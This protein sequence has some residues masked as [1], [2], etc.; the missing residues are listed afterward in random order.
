[1]D[2]VF[3]FSAGPAALPLEVLQQAQAEMVNLHGCGMSVMEMS[4][5]GK[6][7]MAIQAEAEADLRELM[8]IPAN[9]KVLFLQGGASLQFAMVPMNL[10]RGKASADY[11]N[12]GEWSKKAIKEAKKYGAVNV[13][14][15]SED[16]NFSYAPACS[17][18]KLDPNAAYVHITQN[19]TIG[20]VE[21][22]ETPDA[23]NVP[24][25]SDMSSTI[26]SRP[27]DVSK[28][29]LIYAGAQK[30]IGPAGLTIVI[31]REDLIG[32]TV[33]STPTMMD[34]QIQAE[35][36]S[37]YNTPPTYA[38]YIAGL[39]FKM[40]KAKGGIAAMEKTNRAKAKIL[41]DVLDASSFFASPVAKE[42]RSLM[43]IPFTLKNADLDEEFIKGAKARG[44][45]QLQGHRSVGGM[46]ASI[47]N[48]MPVEGVQAL[49]DFMREFE[50]TKA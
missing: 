16:K 42:N 44:M 1:M 4:H 35:N 30:N 36:D 37:M 46:R 21:I 14:A 50:K 13:I 5:R 28:F 43:N 10:L 7:Y 15:S 32:Q 26:L 29:G 48:A 20:G 38:I 23:G 47:Y 45:I 18:W 33:A 12:T 11:L 31:V 19:E 39:V 22:F 6:E 9:Y 2:R 40:L 34:Y 8:G 27:F 49:A 25:V 3:N 24:L 41:Y 17:Q